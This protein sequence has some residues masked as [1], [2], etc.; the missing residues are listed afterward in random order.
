MDKYGI[1]WIRGSITMTEQRRT[2]TGYEGFYE[3]TESGRIFSIKSKKFMTRC[4]DEYGFHI[5]KLYK[6][7]KSKNHV[8]I[9]LWKK[10]FEGELSEEN[11]KGALKVKYK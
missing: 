1:I 9:D 7:G 8:V 2:I 10:E 3:I 5:V 11:F 6:N 4:N